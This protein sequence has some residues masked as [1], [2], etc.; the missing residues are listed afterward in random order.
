MFDA[1]ARL[2]DGNARRIGLF[3][4]LFFLVAGAL[5]GSVASR[6]DP[7]GADDPATEAVQARQRLEDAGLHE[8][9]V[10]AVVQNAPVAAPSS[11]TRVEK[12]ERSV[13]RHPGVESV[14]GYYD[15]HSPVFVSR[16]RRSTYFVVTLKTFAD[17]QWQE[18]GADIADEL[19]ARPGVI[20]GGAAVAQDQ[21]NKQVEKDLR[22]AEM[23]AFPILFLLSFLFF[24]SLVARRCR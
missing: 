22:M 1:L 9:A 16:D 17:K 8:P 20:V 24:R 7:Y 18:T 2:A 3:A 6:L 10:L 23:L 5:G 15:T 13:R 19:S 12:L 14:S 21:V 4:I 11:R